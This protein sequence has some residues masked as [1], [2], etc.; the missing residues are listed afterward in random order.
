MNVGRPDVTGATPID[1]FPDWSSHQCVIVASGPS[2]KGID[3]LLARGRAKF[4]A[5]NNS[6][7]LA[8]WADVLYGCDF[9]WWRKQNGVPG[10]KGI[11]VSQ[12]RKCP[13]MYPEIKTVNCVRGYE[14]SGKMVAQRGSI[15]WGGNG[16]FQA[17]NLGI[18]FG[19]KK[20]V[21]VGFDMRIDKGL[22]W[23]G[24][25]ED[26]LH[27][28]HNGQVERWRKALDAAKPSLDAAGVRVINCSQVSALIAYP[29]M[30]FEDA[31]AA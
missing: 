12:D 13:R 16:G 30:K 29:K 26:G 27:N 8:P 9:S 19:S 21:L 4:I 1:W 15:G 2:A 22:H 7:R 18:Q 25:H 6:W 14:T 11:K 3:L 28:P 23:H 24:K 17:V 5:V 31:L 10:F 20:I